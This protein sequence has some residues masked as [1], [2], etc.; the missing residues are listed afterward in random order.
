MSNKWNKY[1]LVRTVFFKLL[2]NPL[3][4]TIE[5]KRNNDLTQMIGQKSK[6]RE[7]ENE[8]PINKF[9]SCRRDYW[10]YFTLLSS[11]LSHLQSEH[12]RKTTLQQIDNRFISPAT[13]AQANEA[14]SGPAFA[15]Q[16]LHHA[17]ITWNCPTTL[18]E[19]LN[20][21]FIPFFCSPPAPP[22]SWPGLSGCARWRRPVFFAEP[23]ITGGPERAKWC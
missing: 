2:N 20:V 6:K 3:A 17:T 18:G 12:E 10:K 14:S 11:F 22:L 5:Q 21:Q 7:G 16:D 13:A 19:G 15:C 23:L 4:T 9:A 1:K 8:K